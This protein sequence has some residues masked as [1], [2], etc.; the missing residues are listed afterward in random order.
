[1]PLNF[2][3]ADEDMTY[4]IDIYFWLAYSRAAIFHGF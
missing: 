2:H 4:L 1:M 3:Y